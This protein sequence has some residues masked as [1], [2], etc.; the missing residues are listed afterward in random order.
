[1]LNRCVVLSD[2]VLVVSAA[3][4]VSSERCCLILY[5]PMIR[6]FFWGSLFIFFMFYFIFI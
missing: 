1:M 3:L 2:S 6:V 4:L 5:T